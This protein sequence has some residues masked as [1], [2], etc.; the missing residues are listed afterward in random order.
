MFECSGAALE[1]VVLLEESVTGG[2]VLV[3]Q[4]LK[5]GSKALSLPAAYGSRCRTL[6]SFSNTISASMPPCYNYNG[7][8]SEL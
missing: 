5:P 2:W 1:G 8:N 7:L 3:F 4:K 6:S